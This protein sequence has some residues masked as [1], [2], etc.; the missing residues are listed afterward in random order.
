MSSARDNIEAGVAT[1]MLL[2]PGQQ[3]RETTA[4]AFRL[5]PRMERVLDLQRTDRTAYDALPA[6]LH[7]SLGVYEAMRSAAIDEGLY[8]PEGD[9]A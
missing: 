2:T 8:A 1:G 9:A 5:D 3:Q 7:A 4:Q 6:S